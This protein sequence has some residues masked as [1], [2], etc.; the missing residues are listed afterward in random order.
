[1]FCKVIFTKLKLTNINPPKKYWFT[2][3]NNHHSP[4]DW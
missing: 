3:P 1:M 4:E 2:Y